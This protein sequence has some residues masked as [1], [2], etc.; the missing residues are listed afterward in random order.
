M[1]CK[2]P[3]SA[4]ATRRARLFVGLRYAPASSKP[5]PAGEGL[6]PSCEGRHSSLILFPQAV[7]FCSRPNMKKV[8][9]RRAGE[10]LT[11]CTP[12]AAWRRHLPRRAPRSPSPRPSPSGK[13]SRL[14]QRSN[15]P[16]GSDSPTHC[17]PFS[18]SL[19]ERAGVRGNGSDAETGAVANQPPMYRKRDS[20]GGPG[21]SLHL[22][23]GARLDQLLHRVQDALVLASVLEGRLNR[24][25]VG[26]GV[27]E[28]S[29][30]VDKGMFAAER[31]P[32][33]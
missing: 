3:L 23:P 18:L 22:D 14:R 6:L 9:R 12:Q 7:S 19:R 5:G 32:G 28:I 21:P 10:H 15:I 31:V 27:D 16:D 11:F 2:R 13:G 8:S 30:R 4:G 20:P 24:L 17:W 25:A 33:A 26:A 29:D 1:F